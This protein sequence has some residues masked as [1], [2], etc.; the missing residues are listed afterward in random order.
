MLAVGW[1]SV[2]YH[3][4]FRPKSF[5]ALTECR[6]RL[7]QRVT[8]IADTF[9]SVQGLLETQYR[10]ME[11][12]P[13]TMRGPSPRPPAGFTGPSTQTGRPRPPQPQ[14]SPAPPSG[15]TG[16]RPAQGPISGRRSPMP[17]TRPIM[18]GSRS[19]APGTRPSMQPARS[20]AP[21]SRPPTSPA[22]PPTQ[23]VRPCL[24]YTSDAADE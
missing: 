19:P 20:P 15:T 10:S 5:S 24:L 13:P 4:L 9:A 16:V 22:R 14:R 6:G 7:V 1:L 3:H 17:P 18:H 8:S 12:R 23:S 21:G 11:S 2:P